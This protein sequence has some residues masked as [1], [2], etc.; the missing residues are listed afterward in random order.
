[1]IV[2]CD[3][4]ILDE[5]D[6]ELPLAVMDSGLGAVIGVVVELLAVIVANESVVAVKVEFETATD[7]L[8]VEVCRVVTELLPDTAMAKVAEVVVEMLGTV[9]LAVVEDDGVSSMVLKELLSLETDTAVVVACSELDVLELGDRVLVL[10]IVNSVLAGGSDA[11]G[12]VLVDESTLL[13]PTELVS[14]VEDAVEI[15]LVVVSAVSAVVS[16]FVAV[17]EADVVEVDESKLVVRNSAALVVVDSNRIELAL[18]EAEETSELDENVVLVD[19]VKVAVVVETMIVVETELVSSEVADELSRALEVD[20]LVENKL[21]DVSVLSRTDA[22]MISK[23][24]VESPVVLE[25]SVAV[26]DVTLEI[27]LMALELSIVTLV[28]IVPVTELE[29]D[30]IALVDAEAALLEVSDA[31]DVSVIVELVLVNIDV[32]V[33]KSAKLVEIVLIIVVVVSCD[34]VA[35][36][37]KVLSLWL[38]DDSVVS[39]ELAVVVVG[40][41]PSGAKRLYIVSKLKGSTPPQRESGKL[42]SSQGRAQSAFPMFGYT[43]V[44]LGRAVE[45]TQ[46]CAATPA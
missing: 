42:V 14:V 9:V 24:E 46:Y 16:P 17:A 43:V 7:T 26:V 13:K 41:L 15:P 28:R 1:V 31:D 10:S 30:D 36:V 11:T 39:V 8:C 12:F 6:R 5:I 33:L 34:D 3:M 45:H 23:L 25:M 35:R 19:K 44:M 20:E 37:V 22:E 29:S 38:V 21:A 4:A 2:D 27:G 32:V 40:T 18:V